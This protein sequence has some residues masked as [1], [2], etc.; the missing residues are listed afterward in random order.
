MLVSVNCEISILTLD[1]FLSELDPENEIYEEPSPIKE[2]STSVESELVEVDE[3]N[4]T[5]DILEIN[6]NQQQKG[7]LNSRQFLLS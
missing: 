3:N 1:S 5:S 6:S 4:Q 7:K 2:T